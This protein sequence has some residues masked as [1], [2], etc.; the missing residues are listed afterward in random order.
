MALHALAACTFLQ[1]VQITAPRPFALCGSGIQELLWI[2]L[3]SSAA[4]LGAEVVGFPVN[5]GDD[6]GIAEPDF[7]ATH[8]IYHFSLYGSF[9]VHGQTFVKIPVGS[10]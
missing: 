5:S 7:H 8:R 4:G 9:L 3:E 1:A 10:F 2:V 6:I